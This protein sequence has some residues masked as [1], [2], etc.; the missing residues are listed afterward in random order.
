MGEG[1]GGRGQGAGGRGQGAGLTCHRVV[2]HPRRMVL[3]LV[4]TELGKTW[5]A[6]V[7]QF[8]MKTFYM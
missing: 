7:N 8:C 5:V 3:L 1:A 2:S 6:H 4:A